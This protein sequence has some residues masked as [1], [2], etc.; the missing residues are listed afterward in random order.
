[1]KQDDPYCAA[2]LPR[3]ERLRI[4][5]LLLQRQPVTQNRIHA[6]GVTRWSLS[7]GELPP[8]SAP[9]YP[10]STV[11]WFPWDRKQSGFMS[12][13][14]FYESCCSDLYTNSSPNFL[15]PVQIFISMSF[16]LRSVFICASVSISHVQPRV[17]SVPRDLK[18]LL[19]SLQAW[20][21]SDRTKCITKGCHAAIHIVDKNT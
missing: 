5:F 1:M 17:I 6:S 7:R 8:L 11:V 14:F 2:G 18:L 21:L 16:S 3:P 9:V 13:M 20:I 4:S 10:F 12:Q 19:R 15:F